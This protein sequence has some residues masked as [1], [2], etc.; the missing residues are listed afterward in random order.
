MIQSVTPLGLVSGGDVIVGG[1]TGP[2]TLTRE[3]AGPLAVFRVDGWVP[4]GT[5][6]GDQD[7]AR[8]HHI[9]QV[10]AAVGTAAADGRWSPEELASVAGAL[11]LPG[12]QVLSL[13]VQ[14]ARL[15]EE[16]LVDDGRIDLSESLRI[17]QLIV[18]YVF[19]RRS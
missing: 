5:P 14:V 4:N 15:A 9:L 6:E 19:S 1:P 16:A 12:S 18:S 11:A 17:A 3:P 8:G 7:E 10:M 2:V 13:M